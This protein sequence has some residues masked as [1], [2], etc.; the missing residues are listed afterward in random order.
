M[1]EAKEETEAMEEHK[2]EDIENVEP[3]FKEDPQILDDDIAFKPIS[4]EAPAVP[5]ISQSDKAPDL[6]KDMIVTEETTETTTEETED[7]VEQEP[8][9][10]QQPVLESMV[11]VPVVDETPMPVVEPAMTDTE[12]IEEEPIEEIPVSEATKEEEKTDEEPLKL[13]V[14]Q[15]D[16]RQYEPG[17]EEKTTELV[18]ENKIDEYVDVAPAAPVAPVVPIMPQNALN[19]GVVEEAEPKRSRFFYYFLLF[20]LIA[21]AIFTLW[22]YQKNIKPTTP[23]LAASIEKTELPK[24]QKSIFNKKTNQ[25]VKTSKQIKA[26]ATRKDKEVDTMP[27]FLDEEPVEIVPVETAPEPKTET[28]SLVTENVEI[29][30]PKDTTP[31]VMDAVPARVT[32]SG[33]SGENEI[34]ISSEDDILARKPEYQPGSKYDEMF[35]ADEDA[36]IINPVEYEYI[37][38]NTVYAPEEPQGENIVEDIDET[39]MNAQP[40]IFFD[41]EEAAYQAEQAEL[42]YEE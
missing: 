28:S 35:V 38:E 18:E 36:E 10:E 42:Y 41:E 7:N 19:V 9:K 1:I 17:D 30:E 23:V 25:K 24:E 2:E 26:P 11:P 34:N 22:F 20:L 13:E 12:T 21:L 31:E 39:G 40:D 6:N 8:A 32:T 27:A 15:E 16:M 4:F 37:E 5:E 33:Q 14:V 3:L 29:I